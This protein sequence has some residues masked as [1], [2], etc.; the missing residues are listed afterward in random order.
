MGLLGR[1]SGHELLSQIGMG[2][3]STSDNSF[4][5]LLKLSKF[6]FSHPYSGGNKIS[7]MGWYE[8]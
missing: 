5:N 6:Y 4:A 3:I 2:L 8:N 1:D 7:F